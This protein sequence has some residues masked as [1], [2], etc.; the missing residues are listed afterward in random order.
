M[1]L[2]AVLSLLTLGA[3]DDSTPPSPS[4]GGETDGT[5]VDS[6]ADTSPPL[7]DGS[8]ADCFSLTYSMADPEEA[9]ML[10]GE[11]VDDVFTPY[12]ETG[13]AA[14]EWGFQGG[15]M[16]T[17][18]VSIPTDLASEGDCVRVIFENL[19]DPAFPG[20]AEGLQDW[21]PVE[22]VDAY[23][24]RAGGMTDDIFDQIA[25]D[26][27][28]GWRMLLKVTV[29]GLDFALT[30]T[31]ALEIDPPADVPPQCLAL[32]T[33]GEGCTYRQIPGEAMITSIGAS[34]GTECTDPRT[35]MGVFAPTD[36]SHAECYT[37]FAT[38]L[39]EPQAV[40]LNYADPPS[41]C[42]TG[43]DVGTA[44]PSILQVVVAGT[45]PP[46]QLLVDVPACADECMP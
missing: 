10:V 19:P 7:P 32:P 22:G 40:R 24:V 36:P 46:Y 8:P 11:M 1:S 14:F 41:S 31:V 30:E 26:D 45:C 42:L 33:V 25:W 27:P 18:R 34:S 39:M 23:R 5:V 29:R 2:V 44:I 3:C 38:D 16:I 43:Y 28:T 9:A 12:S 35:V 4:D 37:D 13:H 17:P 6:A 21:F 20:E 15:T